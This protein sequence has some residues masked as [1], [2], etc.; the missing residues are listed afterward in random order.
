MGFTLRRQRR[1]DVYFDDD[2]LGLARGAMFSAIHQTS[3]SST[4]AC[5]YVPVPLL[6]RTLTRGLRD[7]CVT[8]SAASSRRKNA[9][10]RGSSRRPGATRGRCHAQMACATSTFGGLVQWTR[11]SSDY[12]ADL[13]VKQSLIDGCAGRTIFPAKHYP[14]VDT[15]NAR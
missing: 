2:G 10:S 9:V 6:S 12:V 1:G 5:Y 13:C 4:E 3:W 14:A 11:S 7:C 8:A 15:Q